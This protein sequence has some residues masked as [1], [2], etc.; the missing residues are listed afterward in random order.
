MTV[1][2][3]NNTTLGQSQC[4]VRVW[5]IT[6]ADPVNPVGAHGFNGST[7]S[8]TVS[9]SYTA[10]IDNGQGFLA[11]CDWTAVGTETAGSGC[12][13]DDSGSLGAP[14]VSYGF[15]HR[16]VA[17]DANGGLT[18]LNMSLPSS[19]TSLNW[20]YVEIQPGVG[21]A[22][23][24][25]PPPQ[26]NYFPPGWGA[27]NGMTTPWL[28]T[29][30]AAPNPSGVI[31]HGSSP[32]TVLNTAGTATGLTT[33]SF[34]PPA[35]SL[36]LIL[37]SGNS[38]DP[39]NPSTPTITD[40]LGTPLTYTLSDWQSRA[41]S[42]TTDGQAASWTAP[43]VTSA[44]M[45]VTVNNN[46]ASPNRHAAL[47]V[48]VLTDP[49]GR[50]RV[51]AHGKSGSTSAALITQSYTAQATGGQGFFAVCDW[52]AVGTPVAGTD[53]TVA[54]PSSTGPGSVGTIPSQ[55][56]YGHFKRTVPDDVN[57]VANRINVSLPA[58]STALNW[59]HVEIL[60]ALVVAG[61]PTVAPLVVTPP[62]ARVPIP[63]VTLGAS[64]P[65]GNPAVPTPQPLVVTPPPAVLRP[66]PAAYL[67]AN[68]AAPAAGGGGTLAF[69]TSGSTAMTAGA[70]STTI[71]I[72][73][74]AVGAICYVWI[75]IGPAPTGTINITG[76]TNVFTQTEDGTTARYALLRRVKQAG[77]TTFT[78]SWINSAKGTL[79]W[80]SYTGQ[81]AVTP[82]EGG[83]L[84]TN[85]VT[86]RTA[87]PTPSGTPTA[88]DR[89]AVGFFSARTSTVG[90]KPITWTPDAA[91]NE[92][93]DVDNN[94][95]GSAPWIGNEI[96]DSNAAVTQSAHSYT[97]TH[98]AAESHDGSAILFL[99]PGAVTSSASSPQPLV[100]SPPWTPVAIPAVQISASQPLGNPAV[101]SP[102][103]L[104]VTPTYVRPPVPGAL[105]FGT[106]GVAVTPPP[107]VVSP[108]FRATPVPGALITSNPAAPVVSGTASPQ[109][110]VVTP[111]FTPVPTPPVSVTASQPLGNPAVPTPQPIVVTA[112]WTAPVPG[113]KLY[114]PGAP[115]AVVSTVGTP[116]PLV[117]GPPFTPVPIPLTYLSASQPLG[118]PAVGITS[119]ARRDA[120]VHTEPGPRREGVRQPGRPGCR[121][122]LH[123][124][125]A[126]RHPDVHPRPGPG[127]EGLRRTRQHA[128][129]RAA[130]RHAAVAARR[131]P[132]D[133]PV[134]QL[135]ARQSG[136]AESPAARGVPAAPVDAT[137]ARARV[138]DG[139][140]P[141][142]PA[143]DGPAEHRH[144]QPPGH[145]Y[146]DV[147][148]RHHRAAEHR[149]DGATGQRHHRRVLRR[150]HVRHLH[151]AARPDRRRG[152]DG[153]HVHDQ[154]AHQFE[155]RSGHRRRHPDLHDDVHGEVPAEAAD[156]GRPADH[157]RRGA[158]VHPTP[159]P[160]VAGHDHGDRG[161]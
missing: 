116:G 127:S 111:P 74:A 57:T 91:L 52:A 154:T 36:L 123:H 148:D 9:Q 89:W 152:P 145:R 16:S 75:A 14:D 120:G 132:E 22:P 71:D 47:T 119:A 117:V 149:H 83:T 32:E 44:P 155:H 54:L 10:Q 17:D 107:L 138:P 97:G 55:I 131:D 130:P 118:N 128:G 142:L 80:V 86:S 33:S 114:G 100:V 48:L 110:L 79:S 49:N 7:S 73:A 63:P 144:H 8:S 34:T 31:I 15:C 121:R 153:R 139:P 6:G 77:D 12:T 129:A 109:P 92:R 46:A 96:A 38:I 41:D 30:N 37:W 126:G 56:S 29:A 160:V 61:S 2:V 18:T 42:P 88:A 90:N 27:P 115:P 122:D 51:G 21:D 76:W 4:A 105:L 143:A 50:P 81:D 157:R 39:T 28:G 59:V 124:R 101:G 108:P 146:D 65:L 60:P 53:C 62:F 26:I 147:R 87:V 102:E 1:S 103:P 158:G 11:V 70:T 66:P 25:D 40:S 19:S 82:D 104:V 137:D 151:H 35:G 98:N 72:T 135:P 5:V 133:L 140:G 156:R 85:G 23:E 125:P 58:S 136:R 64:Q 20:S 78:V 95:A 113:A 141:L 112:P 43:V 134:R 3:T 45:T 99:I 150:C 13:L 67:S 68:A 161:R 84:A 69:D 93:I 94:A 159:D 24:K 106:A